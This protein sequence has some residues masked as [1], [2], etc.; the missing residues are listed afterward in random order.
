MSRN[1]K[2]AD[3]I[4]RNTHP[5]QSLVVS[6]TLH[7][8]DGSGRHHEP[9]RPVV[10]YEVNHVP[11]QQFY[12]H[13]VVNH[14]FRQGKQMKTIPLYARFRE[15]AHLGSLDIIFITRPTVPSLNKRTSRIC[16]V[17]MKFLLYSQGRMQ[18]H[19]PGYLIA[20]GFAQAHRRYGLA[21]VWGSVSISKSGMMDVGCRL[22]ALRNSIQPFLQIAGVSTTRGMYVGAPRLYKHR[23]ESQIV[24]HLKPHATATMPTR[25]CDVITGTSLS[26]PSINGLSSSAICQELLQTPRQ[27]GGGPMKHGLGV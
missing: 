7:Q 1:P 17:S 22:F 9:L 24:T 19:L 4:L 27:D 10:Y 15:K 13:T 6:R 26:R 14:V 3:L 20:H 2:F 8:I 12:P 18:Y 25:E 21:N 16:G 23:L 11:G 5:Q